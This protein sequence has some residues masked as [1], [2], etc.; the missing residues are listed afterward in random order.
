MAQYEGIHCCHLAP[1]P[2][3]S[4]S[5]LP[6]SSTLPPPPPPTC[7]LL[8]IHLLFQRGE[9]FPIAK[10]K[11][12]VPAQLPS[13]PR[14]APPHRARIQAVPSR[15]ALALA[16]RCGPT[17]EPLARRRA[18][19]FKA[20]RE[21]LGRARAPFDAHEGAGPVRID[22]VRGS[23]CLHTTLRS[24]GVW[25]TLMNEQ[26]AAMMTRGN[27]DEVSLSSADVVACHRAATN[28]ET[29]R[30]QPKISRSMKKDRNSERTDAEHV[31]TIRLDR[32]HSHPPRVGAVAAI[33]IANLLVAF[34]A[35]LAAAP[36]APPKRVALVC[37]NRLAHAQGHQREP[38]RAEAGVVSSALNDQVGLATSPR[39]AVLLRPNFLPGRKGAGAGTVL[40]AIACADRARFG[41]RARKRATKT[42][43]GGRRRQSQNLKQSTSVQNTTAR[44]KGQQHG[45]CK[46]G[47]HVTYTATFPG[48]GCAH[49]PRLGRGAAL[50]CGEPPAPRSV[51]SLRRGWPLP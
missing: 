29:N 15:D 44:R 20:A 51:G 30:T 13:L 50:F 28:P 18:S 43:S 36:A 21:P 14:P 17:D 1:T 31:Q 11:R 16:L 26:P 34:A 47:S 8:L 7:R 24:G 19:R 42:P 40:L 41:E 45:P 5:L 38:R 6:P 37:R 35:H 23:A 46:L 22:R 4:S 39:R 12:H 27:W 9:D 2:S 32:G 3:F 33:V 49:T 10:L 48:H 25:V